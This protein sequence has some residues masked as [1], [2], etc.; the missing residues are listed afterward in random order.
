LNITE[1]ID[2]QAQARG[3]EPFLCHDEGNW[4]FEEFK[5]RVDATAGLLA[6]GGVSA[7]DVVAHIFSNEILKVL[8]FFATA[9]LGATSVSI[10][11]TAPM[12]LRDEILKA[13]RTKQVLSDFLGRGEQHEI[14]VLRISLEKCEP[15]LNQVSYQNPSPEAFLTIIRGSGS[16]GASKYLP[17]MHKT[18][19]ARTEVTLCFKTYDVSDRVYCLASFDFSVAKMRV[20][21]ALKIGAS[22]WIPQRQPIDLRAA[23]SEGKFSVLMGTVFHIENILKQVPKDATEWLSPLT[24][25]VL[26]SS[27]VSSRLRQQIRTKLSQ[28]LFVRYGTNESGNLT[29]TGLDDVF[30]VEGGVGRPANQNDLQIVDDNDNPVPNGEAGIIRVK[31]PRL[32]DGYLD[33]PEA[34]AKVFRDGWFYPRDIGRLTDDGILVY[35]GRADD[36]MIRNGINI[37]PAEVENTLQTHPDV[38]DAKVFSVHH[39][40]HQD[41]PIALVAM[42]RSSAETDE[43][44]LRYVRD[45]MGGYALHQ[46]FVTDVLPRNNL[47]KVPSSAARKLVQ[48]HVAL[49]KRAETDYQTESDNPRGVSRQSLH[50]CNAAFTVPSEPNFEQ[51]DR[52]QKHI[53]GQNSWSDLPVSFAD[54]YL[55]AKLWLQRALRLALSLMRT[56]E[57]PSLEEPRILSCRPARVNSSQWQAK[58]EIPLID[59]L[60]RAE[61]Y[62][63]IGKALRY[64]KWMVENDTNDENLA[65]FYSSVTRTFLPPLRKRLPPGLPTFS[66]EISA[67]LGTKTALS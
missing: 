21:E 30:S 43:T 37:Y 36:L 3:N 1:I 16:T 24:A 31:V 34:I 63:A 45:R 67:A 26:G 14:P 65:S 54:P 9:R 4:T 28:R 55:K 32:I 17:I 7:G 12:L 49:V 27:T 5:R 23:A 6:E 33:N 59:G 60:P 61:L 10:P 44:L 41:I 19:L 62:A 38:L 56:V 8:A 18:L 50:V 25:I 64:S 51:L 58:F 53:D 35:L 15:N 48:D 39:E 11:R 2:Q 57:G 42:K 29:M 47:G 46:V 13:T 20:F 22:V 40:I 52:W 66:V